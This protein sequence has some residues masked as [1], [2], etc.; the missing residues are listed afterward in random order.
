MPNSPIQTPQTSFE[1]EI[2]LYMDKEDP[3][4]VLVGDESDEGNR[5]HLAEQNRNFT[6]QDMWPL[7]E[8]RWCLREYAA[9]F[10]GSFF[11]LSFGAGVNATTTFHAGATASYQTNISYLAVTF[12]WAC[13][14][15]IALFISMGVSGGH[16]N[17]AV[18]V[19]N[20]VFGAFPWRKAPGFFL[21]QLLGSM[22]G[23]ANVYGLF[24]SHF[25]DAQQNLLEHET[26]ASKFSGIFVTYPAVPTGYAVWSEVFNTMALMMGVLALT[27]NRMTP[28]VNYKPVA[29]GL[30]VFVIGI[31]TGINSGFAINPTRDLGPRMFTAML[32]GPEPFTLYNYYFWIPTLMPFIGALLGMFLYVFFIIPP[33]S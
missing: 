28:A 12:G 23:A 22:T 1:E 26:M 13:G 19:A 32:W 6:L 15:A 7:Y 4:G 25:D 10:F 8:Y 11:L 31:T 2:Q 30:L 27:D 3:D 21:A 33:R 17:P 16:L 14:L 18:T 24:K 9:E 29:V 20:C 5:Q